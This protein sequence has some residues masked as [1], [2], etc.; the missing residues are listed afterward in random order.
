MRRYS[1]GQG[2]ADISAEQSAPC[3]CAWFSSADEDPRR[4]RD[5]V[6]PA[7]QGPPLTDCL[8]RLWQSLTVLPAQYRMTRS[9]EFGVTVKQGVRAAQPDLVVHVRRDPADSSGPL[10]GLVVGKS[11]GTAVQRHRV[12]RRLRH[13]AKAVLTDIDSSERVVIRA[14]PSSRDVI[15]A[16]LE[17]ELRAGLRRSHALLNSRR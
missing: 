3:A 6:E 10:I 15:S 5:C 4:S 14:L 8:I 9:T 2:Q 17:Q 12:A 16:R 11:V 13:V 7:W 1:R